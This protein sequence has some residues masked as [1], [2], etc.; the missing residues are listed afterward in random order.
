MGVSCHYG[1]NISSR[2]GIV[3][4]QEVKAHYRRAYKEHVR[5]SECDS[6]VGDRKSSP[7]MGS[8]LRAH[9]RTRI[10]IQNNGPG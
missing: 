6:Q 9:R 4:E 1:L 7:K 3:S 10:L 5:E 2:P 8:E